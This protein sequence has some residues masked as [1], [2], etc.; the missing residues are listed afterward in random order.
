M[1][2]RLSA[3]S[4]GPLATGRLTIL[5][6]AVLWSTNGVFIKEIDA[7]ATSITFF[8]CFFAAVFLIPL[9][10]LRNTPRP[11]DVVVGVGLFAALLW[12][13][14]SST[15]ETSAANAVFLQ[16]TAPFY[17]IALAP[18]LL[19]ER[20][21]G[22]DLAALA[23]CL[24]GVVILFG[25]NTGSGDLTGM[26]MG[27]GSGLFFGLY[28]IWLRRMKYADSVLLTFVHCGAVALI[29]AAVPGVWDVSGRDAALLALMAAVQFA[30]PYTLFA[31][32]V[33]TV[34]SAE[35][36]LI[37]LVEPVLNPIWVVLLIGES[38]TVATGIGGAVIITGLILRY[39]LFPRWSPGTIA[40]PGA[41]AGEPVEAQPPEG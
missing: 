39:T 2:A 38:P 41:V 21:R 5:L 19:R 15:K 28:M 34:A 32:G 26:V 36:S 30:I 27:L 23:V 25:G 7:D 16:Y 18:V 8:R 33:R 22:I 14:V 35:A 24:L 3:L 11:F 20:L 13:F 17:V 4:P 9:V 31:R 6:A 1:V 29:F 40:E 37:A 10:R 12:L